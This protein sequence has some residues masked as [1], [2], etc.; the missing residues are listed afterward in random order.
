MKWKTLTIAP[1]PFF[2][3]SFSSSSSD[4]FNAESSGGKLTSYTDS[5][6]FSIWMI[7][8]YRI[9]LPHL[10]IS[11]HVQGRTLCH[12][13]E[14]LQI[15]NPHERQFLKNWKT[16]IFFFSL[17]KPKTLFT[18]NCLILGLNLRLHTGSTPHKF[19]HAIFYQSAIK[20]K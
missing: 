11:E 9:F 6:F 14:N 4:S 19:N 20:Q 13:L 7:K 15:S 16:S 2:L 1:T 8:K 5:S 17:C 12:C 3:M 10:K 18:S